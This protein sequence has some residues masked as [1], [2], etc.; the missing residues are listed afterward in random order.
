ME[1]ELGRRLTAELEDLRRRMPRHSAPPSLVER[2]EEVE[3][4]LADALAGASG[5]ED[6]D[7]DGDDRR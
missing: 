1:S 3:D 2:L 7:A 5:L 6:R 4:A